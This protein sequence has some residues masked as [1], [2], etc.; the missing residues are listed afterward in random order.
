MPQATFSFPT[1]ILYGPGVIRRLPEQLQC[2]GMR[3]PLIV[4]DR[5]L[6]KT[7]IV[8]GIQNLLN[9]A[10]VFSDVDPNPTERNVLEGMTFYN[11]QGCDS[12]VVVG[13]GSAIDAGKAIRLKI[14]HP[15]ELAEYDDN[16]GGSEKIT[17]NL[18]PLI[19]VP[20]TAGTGS[21][22]GRSTVITIEKTN[23]K[24]VIFSP[25]LIPDL[26][27]ADPELTSGMPPK[28]TAGTGM[29]AFT[30]NVEAFLAKG[31]QPICDAIALGGAKIAYRNLPRVMANP[32]DIEARGEMMIAAMMGAIAFQKGLGAVHSLAHPLST[33]FGMHH[34][35]SNAVLL[36]IVLEFN[37]SAVPD[38]FRELQHQLG[39][40]IADCTRELNQIC[41]IAPRLRD[42]GIPEDALPQLAQK[43]IQ[44][45][46][47]LSNP[48]PCTIDILLSLYRRAW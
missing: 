3:T 33:D 19:A 9:E 7:G 12:L 47:H 42:Y 13:G 15:L 41:D 5:G 2:R 10:A 8:K 32:N 1:T 44:D 26:S 14:T 39:K 11:S 38:R 22:V 34:G 17:S 35:T 4:T 24:T 45:G 16:L 27:I 48:I 37:R 18:P 36:P 25:H 20:T 29:D 46:C 23:R 31:F 30:H 28:I 21:E 40:D 6:R 43:A